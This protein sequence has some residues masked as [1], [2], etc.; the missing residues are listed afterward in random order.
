MVPAISSP[1]ISP[2]PL[3]ATK[4]ST[5]HVYSTH[6]NTLYKYDWLKY[7]PPPTYFNCC[8][9]WFDPYVI[10]MVYLKKIC[11]YSILILGNTEH[12]TEAGWYD[13][14][15]VA[16]TKSSGG[17]SFIDGV[18]SIVW[19]WIWNFFREWE[20]I[21]EFKA[22]AKIWKNYIST[23]FS[24]LLSMYFP[25]SL[26]FCLYPFLFITDYSLILSFS[27]SFFLL[28]Y[29][30]SAYLFDFAKQSNLTD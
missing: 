15:F 12:L 5:L 24:P 19:R 18:H 13:I 3:I 30:V 10:L 29:S 26:T 25:P 21:S 8:C 23:P 28:R 7:T 2:P 11:F 6:G 1:V 4:L 20:R 14:F 27:L 9:E 17:L 22:R 16:S